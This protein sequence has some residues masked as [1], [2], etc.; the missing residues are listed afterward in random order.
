MFKR[1]V[2]IMIVVI[3]T[4]LGSVAVD[5]PQ[6][7]EASTGCDAFTGTFIRI[8]IPNHGLADGNFDAGDTITITMSNLSGGGTHYLNINGV[9]VDGPK[10]VTESLSYTFPAAGYYL[11]EHLLSGQ[12]STNIQWSCNAAVP[13]CDV[14]IPI[15][16]QAVVGHFN[17]NASA[18]YAPG[19]L[20][21]DPTVVIEVGKTYWVVGQDAS[22]QF[23]KV[24]LGCQWVWVEF[25][26]VGPNFDAVWNGTPL[27][28]DVVE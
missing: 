27:P 26:T 9:T 16:S 28:T 25:N 11:I 15:P 13:G 2:L 24:L 18:Y 10:D 23:R 14:L 21:T 12:G 5:T 17:T 8:P 4:V 19:K 22:G 20:I 1:L 6:A 3:V 7:A